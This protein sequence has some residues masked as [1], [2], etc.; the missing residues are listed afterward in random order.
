MKTKNNFSN[1]REDFKAMNVTSMNNKKEEDSFCVYGVME[2]KQAL[3]VDLSLNKQ[4]VDFILDTGCPVTIISE[5]I[6]S[7]I[8]LKNLKESDCNLTSYS[9]HKI[10]IVGKTDVNVK[11]EEQCY[12]LPVYVVKDDKPSL[13]GRSWLKSLKLNWKDIICQ[14][15]DT[16]DELKLHNILKK[17]E[18]VFNNE[19]GTYKDR[20]A[21]L[22]LE[23]NARPVFKPARPVPY[24]LLD[25]VDKELD[26]WQTIGVIN[27]VEK[28]EPST[29]WATPLVVV[30]KKDG[31]VRKCGNFKVT[32]NP[33]LECDE[34]PL[35]KIEDMLATIGPVSHISVL[36][37][38]QAYLQMPLSEE[39]KDICVI[40]THKGLYKMQRLPYGI[41][42]EP[43][44]FQREMDHLLKDIPGVKCW[45]DDLLVTCSTEQ[46]ALK[47]LDEVLNV[48]NNAGLRLKEAKCKFMEKEVS[49]LGLKLSTEG[50]K[51]DSTKIKAVIDDPCPTNTKELK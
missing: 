20:K 4:N 19:L 34:H 17:H 46:E 38:S 24:N 13:L 27:P 9:G 15:K 37:L 23:P 22:P 21:H 51:T 28:T 14:V 1:F 3:K 44:T 7:T 45:L 26:K 11:Y 10:N 2:Y 12:D 33:Y 47:N 41:T 31:T 39:S 36:D 5:S 25:A 29:K 18:R 16:T 6:A 50:I 40:N 30:A 8:G 42:T 48:V 32:V 43:A 49:Y 35:P